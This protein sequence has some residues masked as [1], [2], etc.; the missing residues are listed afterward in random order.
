MLAV[1]KPAHQPNT[2]VTRR[3]LPNMLK[4]AENRRKLPKELMSLDTTARHRQ[5]ARTRL[6]ALREKKPRTK[7]AQIRALWPDIKAVLDKGHSLKTVCDCLL[8]D[9]IV[10]TVHTLGSYIT[11]IRRKS[12]RGEILTSSPIEDPEESPKEKQ[13]VGPLTAT[14]KV[15]VDKS[16]DPLANVRARLGK[17]TG[18]DYRPELADPK[19]LI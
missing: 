15:A 18:F 2:A 16:S 5:N 11:R 14:V 13:N 12:L 4:S 19:E 7:A 6:A 10:I 9:G 8:A 17:R 3:S 1:S